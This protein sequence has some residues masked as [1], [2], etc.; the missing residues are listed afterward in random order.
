MRIAKISDT[1][2]QREQN[3]DA[4]L[5][6]PL[7]GN[8]YLLAVADGMGG[9]QAGDVASQTAVTELRKVA[10][11]E[12]DGTENDRKS[13][14]NQAI[15]K[16]NDEIRKLAA[17]NP[18]LEGMGTTVVAAL[19]N[20]DQVLIANVGDSR[21]YL[22]GDSIEQVTED[23]NLARELVELGTISEQEAENHP[24]RHVLSQSL[25]S[26]E[27]IEPDYY[28]IT[29]SDQTLLLCSDGLSEE[30][31]DETIRETVMTADKLST[32]AD[33]L[34]ETANENGGSDNV[35]VVL[36]SLEKPR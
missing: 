8:R 12:L 4:I 17:D 7:E 15:T 23:Q 18:Q 19:V 13:I 35:S 1:G 3:E 24:Q 26:D 6:E 29:I 27:N 11:Q 14:L 9:H 31:T 25:G 21:A 10:T 20:E 28:E 22:I 36:G 30:L 33:H 32:A 34:I 2:R 16:A 5:C